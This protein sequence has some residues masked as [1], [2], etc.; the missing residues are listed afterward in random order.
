[1]P[2]LMSPIHM[3]CP[4]ALTTSGKIKTPLFYSVNVIDS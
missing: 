2:F 4:Y 1:M 3:N